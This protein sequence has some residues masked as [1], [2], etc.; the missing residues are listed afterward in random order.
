MDTTLLQEKRA[1][2]GTLIQAKRSPNRVPVN[3]HAIR[4][5]KQH[6]TNLPVITVKRGADNFYCNG[7]EIVG[8]T[9]LV[10]GGS[11]CDAKAILSCGARLVIETYDDVLVTD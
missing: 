1:E 11:G 7:I 6:G 8:T 5:N 10:Y 9:K 2:I 4:S 3:Q